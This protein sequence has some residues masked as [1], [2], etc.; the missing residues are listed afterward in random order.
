LGQVD[1]APVVFSGN[2]DRVSLW[3]ARTGQLWH[4]LEVHTGKERSVGSGEID[5]D[6]VI[7]SGGEDGTA[8]LWDASTGQ[9]LGQPLTHQGQVWAVAFSP[10]GKTVAIGSFDQTA[11]LWD[12]A[13]ALP[14][15]LERVATWVEVL[16]SLE[17]DELGSTTAL[18]DA[19]WLQRH[20]KLKQLVESSNQPFPASH[21]AHLEGNVTICSTRFFGTEEIPACPRLTP[22]S[23][24]SCPL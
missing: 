11:R 3:D 10:D 17:L 6:P 24:L 19:T 1:G 13:A 20:E 5:D 14:N 22:I 2:W 7:V 4:W 16:T 23:W 18:D 9:P 21:G 15:E 8:R 12:V